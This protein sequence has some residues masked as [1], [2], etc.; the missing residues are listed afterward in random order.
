MRPAA[1]TKAK[2]HTEHERMQFWGTSEH[3]RAL[4]ERHTA[5]TQTEHESVQFWVPMN[6]RGGHTVD[7]NVWK[8][9]HALKR[10]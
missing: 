9:V 6:T 1:K 7:S 10:R 8:S 5:R 3:E 4:H 2:K